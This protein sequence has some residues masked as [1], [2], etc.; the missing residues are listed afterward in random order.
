[1]AQGGLNLGLVVVIVAAAT[2]IAGTS[3]QSGCTT[4]I[5]GLAPCLNY[6]TGNTST[7][8]SSCCSQLA[9]VVKS[10][11][12]CLCS[13]LNGGGSSFGINVNQ[14]LA[15]A[16]PGACNVQTPP[17]SQCNGES[18]HR[19]F[20]LFFRMIG[21]SKLTL[22]KCHIVTTA[23]AAT[24]PTE[25]P[26]ETPKDSPSTPSSPGNRTTTSII[27]SS[28]SGSG[29]KA[30]PGIGGQSSDG[31]SNSS[32][33][34]SHITDAGYFSSSMGHVYPRNWMKAHSGLHHRYPRWI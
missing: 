12:R 7:P 13:L 23:A 25:S 21:K 4:A 20:P 22:F 9:S 16:L 5:I 33:R 6:I 18:T 34:A 19:V 27:P 31:S 2:L 32:K 1:M 11:P 15:L 26:N 8:A 29:S 30:T 10:N 28:P 24:P 14:T 3:A 17:V